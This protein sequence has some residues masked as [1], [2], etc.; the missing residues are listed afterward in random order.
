M[1]QGTKKAQ[2]FVPIV[3]L[4]LIHAGEDFILLL[5]P[6]PVIFSWMKFA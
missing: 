5:F 4:N 3:H 6:I 1:I 2:I